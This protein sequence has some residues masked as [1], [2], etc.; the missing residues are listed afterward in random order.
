MF[1]EW[2]SHTWAAPCNR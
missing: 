1:K 2:R